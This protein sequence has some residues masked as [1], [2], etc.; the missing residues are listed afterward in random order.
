MLQSVVAIYADWS[1]FREL[2]WLYTI[3]TVLSFL[4]SCDLCKH[5]RLVGFKVSSVIRVHPGTEL[6]GACGGQLLCVLL[7]V[8]LQFAVPCLSIGCG[9]GSHGVLMLLE[10]RF[11]EGF[12]ID[13]IFYNAF[14]SGV[15][16][17]LVNRN[18]LFLIFDQTKFHKIFDFTALEVR[19]LNLT[20]AVL[21]GESSFSGYLIRDDIKRNHLE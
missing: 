15:A 2:E 11:L 9:Q 18:A 7:F 5:A 1:S 6:L 12:V 17:E 14:N 16:H 3:L 19:F 20:Q 4:L 13:E 8:I 10:E 21:G